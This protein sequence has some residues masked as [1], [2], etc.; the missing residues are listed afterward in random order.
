MHA[1]GFQHMQS[2]TDRD[3]YVNIIWENIKPNSKDNFKKYSRFEISQQGIP[4]DYMSIMHYSRTAF[5]KN[6]L[7]TIVPLDPFAQIGQRIRLS[8]GDIARVN[9]MY[10]CY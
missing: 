5:S 2:A 4:Y 8:E 10:K 7:S 9:A 3:E 1:I 6:G